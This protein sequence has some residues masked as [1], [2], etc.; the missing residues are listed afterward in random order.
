[1]VVCT[2]NDESKK[3][4]FENVLSLNKGIKE[5]I[6]LTGQDGIKKEI[7]QIP[8][9]GG[10]MS[11]FFQNTH[12]LMSFITLEKKYFVQVSKDMK[13]AGLAS[14]VDQL[15]VIPILDQTSALVG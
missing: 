6:W 14:Y 3:G 15:T 12:K 7:R 4:L 8:M 11:S 10:S 5:L 2:I 9:I 13:D 1:M